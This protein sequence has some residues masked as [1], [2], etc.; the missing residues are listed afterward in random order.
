MAAKC[1]NVGGSNL[2][3][4][5]PKRGVRID[6]EI[7]NV[8]RPPSDNYPCSDTAPNELIG[9]AFRESNESTLARSPSVPSTSSGDITYV[10]LTCLS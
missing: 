3:R 9:R 1:R 4:D 10:T 7:Q 8:G 6:S 5:P 2:L